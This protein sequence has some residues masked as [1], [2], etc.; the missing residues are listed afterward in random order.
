MLRSREREEVCVCV[1]VCEAG[2]GYGLTWEAGQGIE[3]RRRMWQWA[4]EEADAGL[5]LTRAGLGHG[6][7]NGGST[8]E[9]GNLNNSLP[10]SKL[11]NH[12]I[13]ILFHCLCINILLK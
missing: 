6:S 2:G 4:Q 10:F 7:R 1:C 3:R 12:I 5:R 13:M 9:G 8:R 11:N